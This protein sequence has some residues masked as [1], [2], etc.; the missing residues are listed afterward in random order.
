ML[1]NYIKT[2]VRNLLRNKTYSIVNIGGLAVGIAAAIVILLYVRD[3]L[4][5]DQHHENIENVYL[6]SF[7]GN[8]GGTPINAS[9]T[10][11]PLAETLVRKMPEV[12]A[13]ARFFADVGSGSKLVEYVEKDKK[14]YE[15]H[16]MWADSTVF[17]AM[18]IPLKAGNQTEALK[19]PFSVIIT[20]EMADKYFSNENPIGKTLRFNKDQ[21][22][23]ITGVME[24]GYS[25]SHLRY[26]FLASFSS[27]PLSRRTTWLG[28]NT[29]CYMLVREEVIQSELEN[30]INEVIL[31]KYIAPQVERAL[32]QPFEELEKGG[33]RAEFYLQKLSDIY[34]DH[35]G[36][37]EIAVLSDKQYVY[38]FSLVA[39]SL[40]I[41]ASVNYM[42]LATAKASSRA[43]EVGLK[44]VL[45]SNKEQLIKQLLGESVIITF[46]SVFIGYILAELFLLVFNSI[47]NKDLTLTSN[48]SANIDVFGGMLLL[49][50]VVGIISGIYPALII[51]SYQPAVV[52]KGEVTK[53]GKHAWI[54]NGLVIAQFTVS[55]AL[56]SGTGIVIKQLEYMQNRKLGFA[57]DQVIVL[58]ME[59][60]DAINRFDSFRNELLLNNKI[61]NASTADGV[62]GRFFLIASFAPEGADRNSAYV[63]VLNRVSIDFVETHGIEIVAGRD[64]SID[65]PSDSTDA[66]LVN[67]KAAKAFGWTVESAVGKQLVSQIARGRG[68]KPKKVIGVMKDFNFESLQEEIRPL[69]LRIDK[70]THRYVSVRFETENIKE[71]LNFIEQKWAA[72][73][74]GYPFQYKF[75]DEDF[76]RLFEQEKRLGSFF[77]YFTGLAILI[78][79][80]G[81]FS[82]ASFVTSQ[83]TKEIGIRKVLGASSAGLS[84]MFIK[85]FS[86]LVLLAI[87]IGNLIAYFSMDLWLQDF[88]FRT[89]IEINEFLIAG[90]LSLLIAWF[91]V[92]YQSLKAAYANPI[93]SIKY[94]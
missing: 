2:L 14:F 68:V 12:T 88:V 58:Q 23:I 78:A 39:L 16:W 45:G 80:I 77:S 38:I 60:Q 53:G 71:T 24:S 50:V 76:E 74:P 4:S 55:I 84:M 51:S 19:N 9:F 8:F 37:H 33:L 17:D 63:A 21:D 34:L 48:F 56:L 5:Y 18:T 15:P 79:C 46:I 72:F 87:I 75:L 61:L 3:E 52:L 29:Y 66:Y 32:G 44:K 22:Y 70:K 82:L 49:T 57:K 67:E 40:I 28:A 92:G 27:L 36:V 1:S 94:E 73:E 47:A 6:A 93:K 42:N 85:R 86:L 10:A 26:D 13:A 30:K 41:V 31:R 25:K 20:E 90:L 69:V 59:S 64:F 65:F 11:A 35:E 91:T 7:K 54:R 62:P 43:K 89:Q 83:K 81:L